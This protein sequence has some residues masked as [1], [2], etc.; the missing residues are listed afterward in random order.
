MTVGKRGPSS[1]KKLDAERAIRSAREAGLEPA[2]IEI[3][4]KDGTVFRVYGDNAA[5]D[6][7]QAAG[8]KAWNEAIEDLKKATPKRG[9]E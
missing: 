5:L 2:M 8:A 1:F 4:A 6:S 9:K 7:T 3:V